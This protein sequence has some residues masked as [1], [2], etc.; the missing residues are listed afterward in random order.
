M[1]GKLIRV[2]LFF[3]LTPQDLK[4]A[5][6]NFVLVFLPLFGTAALGWLHEWTQWA[7]GKPVPDYAPLAAAAVSGTAAGITAVFTVLWRA[8]EGKLGKGM[9]RPDPPKR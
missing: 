3:G 1:K 4:Y 8:V 5:V 6:R 9:L 7:P 2:L